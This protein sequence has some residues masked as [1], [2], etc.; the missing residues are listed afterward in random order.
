MG[1]R[2]WIVVATLKKSL[3]DEKTHSAINNKVTKQLNFITDQLY[4][5][6][7]VKSEIEHREPIIFGISILQYAELRKLE[8]HYNFFEKF[9]NTEMYEE[10]GKDIDSL[11]IAL[12]EE[13]LEDFILPEKWN[14]WEAIRSRDCTDSFTANATGNFLRRT[15]C[16]AHKKLDKRESRD[17]W[18]N[19]SGVRK[20]CACVATPIVATIKRKT[21]TNSAARVSIKELWKTVEMDPCQSNAKCY[22]KQ[23]TLLQSTED[24]E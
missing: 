8:L 20:C 2:S 14:E 17:Y 16:T 13:N 22:K 1:T 3:N 15:C 4:A 9:R 12:L 18:K 23:S 6:K 24:S 7:F 5:V 11:Y 10:L 21:S 19:T